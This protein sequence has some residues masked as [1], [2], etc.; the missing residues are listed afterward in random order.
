MIMMKTEEVDSPKS[1]EADEKDVSDED[2]EDAKVD[3]AAKKKDK[4]VSSGSKP[5]TALLNRTDTDFESLDLT[6]DKKTP[7]GEAWNFKIACWN[8]AGIK[9]WIK[10]NGLEYLKR[11][12]PDIMCLQETKCSEKTKPAEMKSVP[13]YPH[14]FWCYAEEAN[15]HNGV[16]TLCKIKPESVSNGIPIGDDDSDEDKKLKRSFN[17]EGR[18]IVTEFEKFYL[19]NAYVPNGGRGVKDDK[20]PK[21]YPPRVTNGERQSWDRLFREYVKT[22]EEKKPVIVTGDLNVAHE[23]IDLANPKTNTNAAGFTQEERDG[24]TEMLGSTKLVDSFRSLYP[25]EQAYTFWTYMGNARGRNVGWRLDYF[26]TS[27]KLQDSLADSTIRKDVYGS[28]HCPIVL[29]VHL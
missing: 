16:A 8:V 24:F 19:L 11:E 20:H 1:E 18:L 28:D 7:S 15:G 22:L 29:F 4:T 12:N 10:K 13:N 17:K 27:E 14:T 3:T 9:A 5:D 23:P 6:C 2:P 25:E 21:G 26:L